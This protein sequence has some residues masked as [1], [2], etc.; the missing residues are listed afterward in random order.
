MNISDFQ[1]SQALKNFTHELSAHSNGKIKAGQLQ[2]ALA[3][4]FNFTHP[5]DMFNHI[6]GIYNKPF[7]LGINKDYKAAISFMS[8]VK[9]PKELMC[10]YKLEGENTHK[11]LKSFLNKHTN[12]PFV[13]LVENLEPALKP[14]FNVLDIA[15]IKNLTGM[16]NITALL[17]ALA[18]TSKTTEYADKLF[19]TKFLYKMDAAIAASGDLSIVTDFHYLEDINGDTLSISNNISNILFELISYTL[20]KKPDLKLSGKAPA[21]QA[22][23][24][25]KAFK[26]LAV[27]FLLYSI[28]PPAKSEYLSLDSEIAHAKATVTQKEIDDAIQ[29]FVDN[30]EGVTH[31]DAC[32]EQMIDVITE[33]KV[34]DKFEGLYGVGLEMAA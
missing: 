13:R 33:D 6:D 16:S 21:E 14:L 31:H 7:T 2:N 26:E 34:F 3:S 18:D 11:S 5:K 23:T 20:N 17:S 12:I 15:A 29:W 25:G 8:D 9:P 19:N 30:N 4:K 32:R 24:M 22:E 27:D 10:F 28:S 1:S